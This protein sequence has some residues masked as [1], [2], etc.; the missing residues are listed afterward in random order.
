MDLALSCFEQP[1]INLYIPPQL[2]KITLLKTYQN[3]VQQN[4]CIIRQK[5]R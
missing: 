2:V 5:F 4:T 3:L 1:I